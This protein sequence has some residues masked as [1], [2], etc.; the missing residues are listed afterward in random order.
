MAETKETERDKEEE[1]HKKNLYWMD[2]HNQDGIEISIYEMIIC[3]NGKIKNEFVGKAYDDISDESI[4]LEYGGG[5]FKL[6]SNKPDEDG[7]LLTKIA[8]ISARFGLGRIK[9]LQED[10]RL[11]NKA[12]VTD[13][14][15]SG[16]P[17]PIPPQI[18]PQ[19]DILKTIESVMNIANPL[20][21]K[22]VGA[23]GKKNNGD[24]GDL[25]TKLMDKMTDSNLKF[26]STMQ[27]K[28]L[29]MSLGQVE[30]KIKKQEDAED[31][32]WYKEYLPELL[33]AIKTH[34]PDY[35][36]ANRIEKPIYDKMIKKNENYEPFTEDP[37]AL[38]ELHTL[39]SND[40]EVGREKADAYF[41]KLNLK[42]SP[43]EEE[44]E[45]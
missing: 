31:P 27:T 1:R 32:P 8:H 2:I 3:K 10:E 16:N 24:N 21:D 6:Y 17:P 41:A 38:E 44:V 11:K 45:Q 26:M 25:A 28:I 7:H 35:L 19:R 40:E 14:P 4:G 34:G 30:R 33:E 23:I 42:V 12:G 9:Q 36:A 39:L 20:I 22:V 5:S 29:D 13:E 37:D 43:E 15:V 18:P